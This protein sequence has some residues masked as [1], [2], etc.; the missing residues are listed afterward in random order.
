MS[1][2]PVFLSTEDLLAMTVQHG[3][4]P[5]RDLGLLD[6]AALRPRSSVF[7]EDA[8][9]TLP[10]KAAALLHSLTRH[11]ALVDGNKR[12]AWLATI[13]FLRLNSHDVD[14]RLDDAYALMVDVAEGKAEVDQ[15][16]DRLRVVHVQAE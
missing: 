9:A 14:L 5:V 2:D 6:S 11:H 13:T 7:G 8:Y 16:A 3:L 1:D 4:G 15:I 10:S 12:L